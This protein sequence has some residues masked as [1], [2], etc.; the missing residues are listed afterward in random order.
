MNL[1]ILSSL[2]FFLIVIVLLGFYWIAPFDE[3]DFGFKERNY[4]FSLNS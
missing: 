4:N 2:I 1:K 3:V